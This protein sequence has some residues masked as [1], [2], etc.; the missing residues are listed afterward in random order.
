MN[1]LEQ[2]NVWFEPQPTRINLIKDLIEIG[3]N[4]YSGYQTLIKST[5]DGLDSVSL[6]K[7]YIND[8]Y[9][10]K[11]TNKREARYG[12][13]YQMSLDRSIGLDTLKISVK[14]FIQEITYGYDSLPYVVMYKIKSGRYYLH[15]WI[16]DREWCNEVKTYAR[17]YWFDKETGKTTTEDNPNAIKK[18][19]KGDPKLNKDGNPIIVTWANN[20]SLIF[21]ESYEYTQPRLY[22]TFQA[23]MTKIKSTI[24]NR[25][26]RSKSGKRRSRIYFKKGGDR[27]KEHLYREAA[28]L[29]LYISWECYRSILRVFDYEKWYADSLKIGESSYP[30]VLEPVGKK[31]N[32]ILSIFYHYINRIKHGNFTKENGEKNY[33]FKN[34]R[35]MVGVYNLTV[36]KQM[37]KEDIRKVMEGI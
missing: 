36:L 11:K 7:S 4:K 15:I 31:A 28:A 1:Y 17:D 33:I 35:Y 21:N 9:H 20:K 32:K 29:Q 10:I 13:Y 22:D 30:N 27:N 5:V 34:V 8:N 16:A 26:L 12:E 23:I 24:K 6:M 19:S 3:S 2:Y 18:C 37:F 25:L 14:D